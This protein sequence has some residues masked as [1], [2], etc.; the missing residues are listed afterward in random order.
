MS[1]MKV[2]VE[3]AHADFYPDVL[4]TCDPRDHQAELFMSYPKLIVEVLSESTE[5]NDR[6]PKFASYR[7]LG[8]LEEC[9][10][11]DPETHALES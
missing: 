10:L 11:V 8:S 6:G 4:V 2:R 1:D 3:A 9:V 7:P 5:R